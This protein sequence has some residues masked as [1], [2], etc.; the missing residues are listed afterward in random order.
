MT[1][2]DHLVDDANAAAAGAET[3]DQL[4]QR[5]GEFLGKK[6]AINLAKK[7]LE[8][9]KTKQDSSALL[10]EWLSE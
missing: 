5:Q 7:D 2:Y 6:A 1:T 9:E 3:L 8:P 10:A 4:S